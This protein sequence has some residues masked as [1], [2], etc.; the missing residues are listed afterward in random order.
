[1]NL[2]AIDCST[3][4]AT[5]ALTINGVGTRLEQPAQRQ[6]AQLLLPMVE[7][8]LADAGLLLN[9]LDGI[10][11]GRGPGSFTGLRIACSMAKGLGYAHDLPLY[12]VSTLTAIA[13]AAQQDEASY[14]ILAMIDARMNQLYWACFDHQLYS[15]QELVSNADAISVPGEGPIIVA[16]VNYNLYRESF[17]AD[18]LGRMII[19]KTIYPDA[20]D[21]LQLVSGGKIQP[22]SAGDALPVYI[23]NQITQG[24]ARG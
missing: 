8:L 11:F 18:L 10:V 3:E 6:H 7:Q 17:T 16:G 4:R 22:V 14:P 19:E 9:Q 12:P 5:V 15:E 1:M 21:M 20:A 2:L 23:R 13:Y 24:E